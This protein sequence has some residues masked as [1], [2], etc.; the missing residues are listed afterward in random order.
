MVEWKVTIDSVDYEN[1]RFNDVLVIGREND[2]S[3]I[4][5]SCS[6]TDSDFYPARG[7]KFSTCQV[8]MKKLSGGSY[9]EV[10]DGVLKEPNAVVSSVGKLVLYKGKG[11]GEALENT[12]CNTNFGYTSQNDGLNTVG[13][14]IEDV[15]DNYINKSFGSANTTGY[16]IQSN[17]A[18]K[19]YIPVI[20]AGFSIPF[21]NAPYQTNKQVIDLI[22]QLDTAYRNGATAGPHWF[23]DVNGDIRVKTIGT[24]QVDGG[25]GGG[26]WGIYCGGSNVA[27]SLYEG[28]DFLE[29]SLSCPTGEYANNVCL[30]SDLRKPSYDYWTEDS[31]GASLWTNDALTSITDS[32]AQ[33][34]VGSHSVLFLPNGNVYGKGYYSEMSLLTGDANNGQADVA[35]TDATNFYVGDTVYLWDSTPDS[36][37]AV[38]E[39]IAGNTLTMTG[40]LT[41][42]Y[43]VALSA[44]C[45][46][47]KKWDMTTW[48]SK[49]NV[50]T[51]NF[52]YW[53]ETGVNG[54]AT[55]VRLWTTDHDTDYFQTTYSE[56]SWP[57][58]SGLDQWIHASIPVGPDWASTD[59]VNHW[60][61]AGNADWSEINGIAFTTAGSTGSD[62]FIDDLHFK[63]KII[64]EAV[65]TSEVT[66][67]NEYQKVL[68]S[69][70]P[71]DDT[72]VASLDTGMAASI[73]YA[74]L[75]RRVSPPRTLICKIALRPEVKPGEYFKVYCETKRDGTYN[76]NGVDFRV[77]RYEHSIDMSG[78][79]TTL[80]L[81]DDVMNSYPM[82]HVKVQEVLNEYMLENNAKATDIKG[83]GVDLLI[84]HLRKTY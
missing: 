46:L 73:A 61:A 62:I 4:V 72:A 24:Q 42:T 29:Y 22:C 63:G 12:H 5:F 56:W 47:N 1:D 10:F 68:I 82:T 65:D 41:N 31:G 23:V 6:N 66:S 7:D 80:Y 37:Q 59:T 2:V 77:L 43:T 74:E 57:V 35:I 19:V 83:G 76:V 20:D 8:S 15:I 40:N 44:K 49:N 67:Y 32:A 28:V 16:T 9:I 50:P 53:H 17:D 30:V 38:I 11:L 78:A 48:G 39:S 81:T 26:D 13:E 27:V 36:E 14:I 45:C 55:T 84:S 75:L 64:R 52:Y 54:A 71:F 58:P 34:V 25:V 69:N 21:I 18:G 79:V 60:V 70:T 51:L 3:S 33:Y